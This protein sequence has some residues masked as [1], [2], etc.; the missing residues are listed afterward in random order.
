MRLQLSEV[1]EA[2]LS[3]RLLP[4]ISGGRVAAFE[5]MLANNVIRELIRDEKIHEILPNMEMGTLEGMQT[6]DQALAHLVKK[7]IVTQ[8]DAIRRSSNPTRLC[9]WRVLNL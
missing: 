6:M 1:I 2:V 7:G 4:R 8:E 9:P 5:V 3:Q